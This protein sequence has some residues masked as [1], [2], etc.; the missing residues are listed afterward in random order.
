MNAVEFIDRMIATP[1]QRA[2]YLAYVEAAYF[3]DG[4]EDAELAESFLRR[5]FWE[6][7]RF[8]KAYRE[9]IAGHYEQAGHDFWLTRNGHGAGFWDRPELYGEDVA[10]E[11]TRACEFAGEHDV[12]WG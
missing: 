6:C 4:E 8:V 7:S 12:E 11:L 3:T 2:F 5:A 1:G 10:A 9:Q